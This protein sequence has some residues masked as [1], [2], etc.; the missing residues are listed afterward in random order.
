MVLVKI[1]NLINP[2]ADKFRIRMDCSFEELHL[3]MTALRQ[4]GDILTKHTNDS[5]DPFAGNAI[6]KVNSENKSILNAIDRGLKG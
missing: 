3:I 1:D 2:E 6:A 5:I 4:R